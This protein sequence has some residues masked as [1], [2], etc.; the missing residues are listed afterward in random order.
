MLAQKFS[1]MWVNLKENNFEMANDVG[2][3]LK[4]SICQLLL[5]NAHNG[6]CGCRYCID[7]LKTYLSGTSKPCPGSGDN[8]QDEMIGMQENLQLDQP[9]N[10]K[11][12][13][14]IVKCPKLT[15]EYKDKLI[16]MEEHMSACITSPCPF[17]SIGCQ[18][19]SIGHGRVISHLETNNEIH[20]SLMANAFQ[21]ININVSFNRDTNMELMNEIG[22]LKQRNERS[23]VRYNICLDPMTIVTI[24][25]EL[26]GIRAKYHETSDVLTLV[27]QRLLQ[28]E[29]EIQNLKCLVEKNVK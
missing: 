23:E 1:R 17:F 15:C 2:D 22:H 5:I 26:V 4:C 6:P 9:I 10:F 16:N 20:S 14:I 13:Q 28:A 12:S 19:L 8:C 21:N 25:E 3:E 24:Q 11:I 29:V 27:Q 18:E 7:C